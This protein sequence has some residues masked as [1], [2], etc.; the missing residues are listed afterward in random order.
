ATLL[1]NS[2]IPFFTLCIYFCGLETRHIIKKQITPHS[3]SV[4]LSDGDNESLSVGK[5]KRLEK[6]LCIL[7]ICIRDN[8]YEVCI[9]KN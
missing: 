2:S 3:G 9:V 8:F 4:F 6:R 5:R 7:I 1:K